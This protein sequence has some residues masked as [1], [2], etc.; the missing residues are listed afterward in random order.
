MRSVTCTPKALLVVAVTL[1][2][3]VLAGATGC[4]QPMTPGSDARTAATSNTSDSVEQFSE[5]ENCHHS[6]GGP[7]KPTDQKHSPNNGISCCPLETTLIQKWGS[8]GKK[9]EFAH[10]V[11]LPVEAD[12]L[13]VRN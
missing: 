3:S 6:R 11:N 1:W 8:T 4:M 2:F 5:M 7:S 9:I 13:V 12:L 10:G